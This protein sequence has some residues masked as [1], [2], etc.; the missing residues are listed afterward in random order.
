MPTTPPNRTDSRLIE[1]L[2]DHLAEVAWTLGS[3]ESLGPQAAAQ[4]A[5]VLESRLARDAEFTALVAPQLRGEVGE[6]LTMA[7]LLL[8]ELR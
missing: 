3:V 8:E 1:Q 5:V 4:R 6:L 7:D 2:E